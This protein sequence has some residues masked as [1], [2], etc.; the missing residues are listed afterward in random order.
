MYSMCKPSVTFKEY[1]RLVEEVEI[2]TLGNH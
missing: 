2:G 1:H